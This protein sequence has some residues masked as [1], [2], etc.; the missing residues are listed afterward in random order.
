MNL[1]CG[2]EK[3]LLTSFRAKVVPFHLRIP[4]P[5]MSFL[6][7]YYLII[8]LKGSWEILTEVLYFKLRYRKIAAA[9][10]ESLQSCPTLC[11]P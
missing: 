9:A 7:K 11:D 5:E 3:D 4:S 2:G 8:I 6:L 1:F 10:A